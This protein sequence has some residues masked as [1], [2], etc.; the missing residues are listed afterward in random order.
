MKGKYDWPVQSARTILSELQ[1]LWDYPSGTTAIEWELQTVKNA[2]LPA[3]VELHRAWMILGWGSLFSQHSEHS[4]FRFPCSKRQVMCRSGNLAK[5]VGFYK[6]V[7]GMSDVAVPELVPK[8]GSSMAAVSRLAMLGTDFTPLQWLRSDTDTVVLH[9][10]YFNH[11]SSTL[12]INSW[13]LRYVEAIPPRRIHISV[14]QWCWPLGNSIV[15]CNAMRVRIFLLTQ[16]HL[17]VFVGKR[18]LSLYK[19][20]KFPH[21]LR[22]EGDFYT[23][24]LVPVDFTLQVWYEDGIKPQPTPWEGRHALGCSANFDI[25][26]SGPASVRL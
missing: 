13:M 7:L 21:K 14:S 4:F 12:C 24:Q 23:Q 19:H 6:D 8:R 16:T 15:I 2:F 10:C 3:V 18:K 20:V 22:S 11:H 17:K 1:E 5:T 26:G 9:L 25:P